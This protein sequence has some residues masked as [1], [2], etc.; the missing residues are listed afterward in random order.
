MSDK[1]AP[2]LIGVG[3]QAMVKRATS[4]GLTWEIRMA[5]VRDGSN[6]AAVL[7]Q[8][9]KDEKIITMVSTVG[10][11][12]T[13]SRVYVIEIPPAGNFIMGVFAT[14]PLVPNVQCTNVFGMTP[15]NTTSATFVSMPGPP[16]VTGF[17]ASPASRLKIDLAGT[18]FT[19]LATAGLVV[20]VNVSL[21]S[22]GDVPVTAVSHTNSALGNHTTYAGHIMLDPVTF[23][24][25]GL[26]AGAY[27]ITGIWRR[28]GGTGTLTVDA[29]DVWCCCVEEVP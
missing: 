14:G 29:A 16:T 27:T 21:G 1:E 19:N 15:G 28:V 11:L 25:G 6:P 3:I 17:K 26:P 20:G 4:L 9:D 24:S 18:F 8:Y 22:A 5:T 10:P 13:G 2:D 12:L 7:A 23:T